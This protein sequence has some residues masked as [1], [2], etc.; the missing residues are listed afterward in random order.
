MIDMTTDRLDH[1]AKSTSSHSM[2]QCASP[3]QPTT[4]NSSRFRA[5]RSPSACTAKKAYSRFAPRCSRPVTVTRL[6]SAPAGSQFCYLA[7]GDINQAIAK[8]AARGSPR[9]TLPP[10]SCGSWWPRSALPASPTTRDYRF[11]LLGVAVAMA[12]DEGTPVGALSVAAIETRLPERCRLEIALRCRRQ[13]LS[14]PR[15]F[16]N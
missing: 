14:C 2:R 1:A 12:G 7:D 4:P 13:H 9:S 16:A 5:T 15:P 10:T 3:R 8:N 11:R 6:A